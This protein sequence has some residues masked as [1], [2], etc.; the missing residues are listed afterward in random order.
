MVSDGEFDV[1]PPPTK[2]CTV[3]TVLDGDCPN[4]SEFNN[5][6]VS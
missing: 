3:N 4:V 2:Y 6:L 5:L 1:K